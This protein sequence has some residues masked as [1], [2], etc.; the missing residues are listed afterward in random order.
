MLAQKVARGDGEGGDGA[1]HIRSAASPE[2]LDL[3]LA[4]ERIVAPAREIARRHDIGVAGEDE[5]RRAVA[6]LGEEIVHVGRAGLGENLAHA[7]E[8]RGRQKALQHVERARVGRRDRRA[9]DEIAGEGDGG[10]EGHA[11]CAGHCEAERLFLTAFG[12]RRSKNASRPGHSARSRPFTPSSQAVQPATAMN[13]ASAP[14]IAQ[15]GA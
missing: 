3:D 11:D 8:A 2:A 4:G 9:A 12:G 13:A 7:G 10:R 14:Q 5:M 15:V 1:L 6:D